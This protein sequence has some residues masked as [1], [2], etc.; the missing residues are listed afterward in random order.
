[1]S[2]VATIR[3]PASAFVLDDALSRTPALE[4][5][6]LQSVQLDR[7]SLEP[8]LWIRGAD[9]PTVESW[10]RDDPSISALSR[11]FLLSETSPGETAS[12]R[13]GVYRARLSPAV[14]AVMRVF[15]DNRV[16]VRRVHGQDGSW[17]LRVLSEDRGALGSVVDAWQRAGLSHTIERHV[18]CASLPRST[19]FGL[20][21]SQ[22]HTLVTAYK[23]GYYDIP[24]ETDITSL[25]ERFGISHQATSQRLRRSHRTLV[26]QT[27]IDRATPELPF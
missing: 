23:S 5:R 21:D 20:T 26:R 24:R 15:A 3:I 18:D 17:T 25:A 16:C 7:G 27:L 8:L 22:Y 19:R 10:L 1:M 4:V 9:G 2:S 13:G 14:D 12:A 11:L 6:P